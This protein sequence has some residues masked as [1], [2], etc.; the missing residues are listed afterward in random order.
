MIQ[1][2]KELVERLRKDKPEFFKQLQKLAMIMFGIFFC[3]SNVNIGLEYLELDY[4]ISEQITLVASKLYQLFIVVF[5]FSF[6]PNNDMVK[7]DP[8]PTPIK[9]VNER[10]DPPPTPIKP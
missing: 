9:P 6:L 10:T 2:I 8:P 5:G 1:F 4:R 3:I 7:T